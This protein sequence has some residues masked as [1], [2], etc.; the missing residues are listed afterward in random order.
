MTKL[1]FLKNSYEKE[2]DAVVIE[3]KENFV[4]LNQTLFYG[5]SGGQPG[6]TGKLIF[7]NQEIKIT[8]VKKEKGKIKHYVEKTIKLGTKVHGII[9]FENRYKIMRMHTAQHILSGIILNNFGAETAGNQIHPDYSR[10]DFKPLKW[11]KEK[12]KFVTE[13]F[14]EA[15]KK[16]IPIIF[17]TISRQEMLDKVDSARRKLFERLPSFIKK[18]RLV[19]VS[20]I[21]ICPCAGTH[22]NNT[23]EIGAIKII[24][25]ENKGAE[26]VRIK[27][28]LINP[29]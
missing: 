22:V 27:Y 3:S 6:D 15:V 7:D 8:N 18:I 26:T 25:N 11:D 12:E 2:F 4:I 24:S 14:N 9:N 20:D 19:S 16:E 1:L 29:F 17:E 28:E 23:K 21:D 13:K 10:V 5:E